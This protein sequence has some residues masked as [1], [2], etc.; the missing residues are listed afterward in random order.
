MAS[1]AQSQQMETSVLQQ[2]STLDRFLPVWIGLA[3]VIGIGLGRLFPDLN[4]TL[5]KIKIDQTSLPIAIGLLGM[6]YPVLA[7]VKYNR[8]GDVTERP[9]DGDV[10]AAAQLGRRPGADVR[11]GLDLPRPTCRSSARASSSSASRAASPWC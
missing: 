4:D 3:M 6:M 10:V 9:A 7:K 8:L 11:A 2:L 5:D 1:Y